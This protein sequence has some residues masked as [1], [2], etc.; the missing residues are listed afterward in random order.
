MPGE[1]TTFDPTKFANDFKEQLRD[2]VR[3]GIA[4]S[5]PAEALDQMIKAEVEAFTKDRWVEPP[6]WAYQ[7]KKVRMPSGLAMVV[8]DVLVQDIKKRLAAL[9][10]SSEWA[11][12][13]SGPNG[14]TVI[15][16]KLQEVV[17]KAAPA[18][19][20]KLVSEASAHLVQNLANSLRSGG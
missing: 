5:I 4:E 17:E 20:V 2:R 14:E 7:E 13:W 1:M 9:L 16:S 19:L 3:V 6:S 12:N 18:V 11:Q 10:E 8:H 15:G